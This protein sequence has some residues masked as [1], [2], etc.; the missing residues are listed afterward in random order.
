M[1]V[2]DNKIVSALA[3]AVPSNPSPITTPTFKKFFIEVP[4]HQGLHFSPQTRIWTSTKRLNAPQT[5][6]PPGGGLLER[7]GELIS[8]RQARQRDCVGDKRARPARRIGGS[9]STRW[10]ARGRRRCS[11]GQTHTALR[12][13]APRPKNVD[14]PR[15]SSSPRNCW[16]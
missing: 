3:D 16:F 5:K 6:R 12:S 11:G 2:N 4:I 9:S 15:R 10:R 13:T 7:C 14:R 1:S 8:R